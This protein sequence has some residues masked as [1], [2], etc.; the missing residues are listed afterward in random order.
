MNNHSKWMIIIVTLFTIHSIGC[1]KDEKPSVAISRETMLRG[2]WEVVSFTLGGVNML[3]SAD[4]GQFLCFN[5]DPIEYIEYFSE[6]PTYW[7]FSSNGAWN[8]DVTYTEQYL[9]FSST[10]D[11]CF[12]TYVTDSNTY[13]DEGT[14]ALSENENQIMINVLGI[15]DKW[16]ITQMTYNTMQLEL[17]GGNSRQMYL[18]KK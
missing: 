8:S 3:Y 7:N 6:K 12:A 15:Q 4:T 1:K 2:Q 16:N 5:G 9:D 13:S 11:N 18:E 14:W 10:Y 17:D